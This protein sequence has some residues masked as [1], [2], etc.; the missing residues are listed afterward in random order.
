MVGLRYPIGLYGG[1]TICCPGHMCT[2]S[3]RLGEK[4]SLGPS[5]LWVGSCGEVVYG[6]LVLSQWKNS[7]MQSDPGLRGHQGQRFRTDLCGAKCVYS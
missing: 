6:K 7:K 3:L 2:K 1:V 4:K 5:S